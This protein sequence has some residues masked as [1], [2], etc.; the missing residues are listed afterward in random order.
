M[1]T[2]SSF[3]YFQPSKL[4][5]SLL[6]CSA[7]TI[8]LKVCLR[9]KDREVTLVR[10]SLSRGDEKSVALMQILPESGKA[11]RALVSGQTEQLLLKSSEWSL[12]S[13]K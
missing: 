8:P 11:V 1:G 3:I 7:I 4:F 13:A 2:L 9:W 5:S 12:E 10:L 6:F